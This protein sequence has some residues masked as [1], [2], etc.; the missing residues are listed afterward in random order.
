MNYVAAGQTD[1]V[2][3]FNRVYDSSGQVA[4]DNGVSKTATYSYDYAGRLISSQQTVDGSC[5]VHNYTFDK[6]SNRTNLQTLTNG[7][8]SC[9]A[10]ATSATTVTNS[11]SHSF[12]TGDRMFL[13]GAG[14][15]N[16]YVYDDL[17]NTTTLPNIDTA[18][19]A[20]DVTLAY[21]PDS[22]V[23]S[24]SQ[25]GIVKTF[26]QDP[27]GRNVATVE[28]STG[29]PTVTT[30]NYFDD[31]SDSPAWSVDSGLKWTRN[32]SDLAGG[33]S[34]LSSGTA[35]STAATSTKTLTSS[36]VQ[37]TDM[38]GDVVTTMETTAGANTP[39]STSA[40]DEY[41]VIVGSPTPTPTTYGWL[42][43]R[44]RGTASNGLILMGVRLYNPTTGR[45]LQADPVPGGT[46]APFAYPVDPILGYDVSGCEDCESIANTLRKLLAELSTRYREL[47]EDKNGLAM[48]GENSIE[49]HRTKYHEKQNR[50][51]KFVIKYL[52]NN[53]GGPGGGMR[54]I[55]Q[56]NQR[57][58]TKAPYPQHMDKPHVWTK[59]HVP[60]VTGTIVNGV[61]T[62]G[63]V[64]V[65][66]VFSPVA[67]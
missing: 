31:A 28:T 18:N 55:Q 11:P 25:A 46:P 34:V 5:R 37:L 48:I 49:G 35:S 19:T 26:T 58:A 54:L 17:G 40:F 6:D 51:R 22:Q 47:R 1:A 7:D 16:N 14:I 65:A 52:D 8:G 41:G 43:S 9:P 2:A 20:G 61:A 63:V 27:L 53:C 59:I 24:I 23:K 62:V 42:G 45:F 32:I 64:L 13:A 67:A 3:A 50:L 12:D 57:L 44:Q 56:A 4:A 21:Q 38:H 60:T 36:S 39:T 66:I 33:L 29:S 15:A 30:V 10:D